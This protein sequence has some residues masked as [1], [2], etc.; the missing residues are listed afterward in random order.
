MVRRLLQPLY[1]SYIILLFGATL[2]I[3][4]PFYLLLSLPNTVQ[5]RK[6]MWWLTHA[7]SK[8]WLLLGGMPAKVYGSFPPEGRFIIIS[9]HVSYLDAIVIFGILPRYFRPLAK[10]EIAKVPLFGFI[11]SQI[12]LLIDRSTAHSRAKSTKLMWRTLEEECHVFIYPEGT[13]NETEEPMKSF[14]D[15]AF[16]LAI[17]TGTPILPI[18][19]PD[20]KR[21]WHYSHWWSIW[22]G[23]NRAY[24]L[25]P[26]PVSEYAAGDVALLKE[27]TRALMTKF[28]TNLQ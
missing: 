5:S 25:P 14:Y 15:G 18:I 7:W 1:T 11:Y 9:N 21:R 28:S 23:K 19:L 26:V 2:L 6:A 10:A 24:L 27:D 20:T 4:L 8:A 17:K 16:R 12:A 13:F 22:P 3:V